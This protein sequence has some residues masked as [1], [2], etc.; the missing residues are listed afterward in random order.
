MLKFLIKVKSP[1]TLRISFLSLILLFTAIISNAQIIRKTTI[2][3]LSNDSLLVTAD[4]YF[5]KKSNPFIL[6]FHT[7]GSSRGEMEE[8]AQRFVKMNFNC[9]AVDLRYGDQHKFIKNETAWRAKEAKLSHTLQDSEKDILAAIA[10]VR[11]MS[12]SSILLL[13]SSFSAGLCIKAARENAH[14]SAVLA[15]SPGE[16]FRPYFGLKEV[17][18]GFDKKLFV[19]GS[20]NEIPYLL[21]IFEG[22]DN[23]LLTLYRPS[24]KANTRGVAL[25]NNKNPYSNEVWLAVL[26]FIKS[27]Q[28]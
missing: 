14:V 11:T 23:E 6:L 13:G 5:S 12:D 15:F 7:E 17:A 8:I 25:L 22:M 21:E 19:T 20:E 2:N 3:F 27:L 24:V 26:I 16:F 4:Q 28:N 1:E 9:L 10:F 18:N